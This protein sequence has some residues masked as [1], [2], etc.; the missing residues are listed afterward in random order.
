MY[1]SSS[2]GVVESGGRGGGTLD[3]NIAT[4][5]NPVQNIFSIKHYSP[6]ISISK[7]LMS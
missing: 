5:L 7:Q 6:D 1:T 4:M 2:L 3:F